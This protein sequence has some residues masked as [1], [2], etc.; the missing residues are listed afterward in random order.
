MT[1][2]QLIER[3][4]KLRNRVAEIKERHKDEL[5]TFTTVMRRI[6]NTLLE[7]LAETNLNAVKGDAGTAYQQVMTSVTVDDWDQTLTYVRKQ[8]AWDL[9]EARVSKQAALT[10]IEESQQPIPGVKISQVLVLR[11]R[12]N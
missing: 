2:D 12:T 9:L 6:E 11:V 5:Q 8:E 1:P 10:L 7:H 3:Y 4:I